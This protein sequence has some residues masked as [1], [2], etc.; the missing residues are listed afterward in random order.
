MERFDL[1]EPDQQTSFFVNT[2]R[3]FHVLYLRSFYQNHSDN[4]IFMQIT[5]SQVFI[6]YSKFRSCVQ[7]SIMGR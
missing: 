1:T 7:P 2:I 3:S 5:Y 4:F 6:F